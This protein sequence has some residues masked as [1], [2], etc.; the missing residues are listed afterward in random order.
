MYDRVYFMIR[1]DAFQKVTVEHVAF[2]TNHRCASNDFQPV[3]HIPAS[4]GKI[5]E[6]YRLIP[7][8]LQ[9]DVSMRPDK[10]RAASE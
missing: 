6:D 9:G 4:I 10:P 7:S 5:I 8:I 1:E 3:R 2:D